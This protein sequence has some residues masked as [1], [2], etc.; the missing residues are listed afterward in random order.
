MDARL[1]FIGNSYTSRNDLPR[2]LADLAATGARPRT[3]TTRSIVAGGASLKRHWNGGR[4]QQALQ[5]SAWDHVVLQEQSTLPV[6]NRA[7]YHD[8]VRLFV[9]AV[10]ERGARM[11]LY[12]VWARANAPQSQR[13]L[14]DAAAAIAA[15]CDADVVP[16][17]AAW[18]VVLRE[19]P[20]VTLFEPDGSHPTAAGSYVAACTFAERLLD[21]RVRGHEVSDALKLDRGVAA[22]LQSL[23]RD[24]R[25]LAR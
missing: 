12:V 21:V 23:A 8:N 5:A 11:A 24:Q 19:R 15:E 22:Y 3:L 18:A 10:R 9:D 4:V 17:G 6:K 2:M 16:V 25:D 20:D 1:L 13:D 7:R 14:D